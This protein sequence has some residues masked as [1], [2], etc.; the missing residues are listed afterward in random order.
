[1]TTDF[2]RGDIVLVNLD[3]EIGSEI[4]KT[5]PVLIIQNDIGNKY[6]P[7]TIIASITSTVFE[8]EFLTNVYLPSKISGLDKNSTILLNQ[9]R[10]IDKQR[11]IKKIGSL[12]SFYL[13]KVDKALIISLNLKFQQN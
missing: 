13:K 11:I 9:I 8:K 7:V 12:N 5:R 1:M 10:T 3:P 6:S 2:S 4:G